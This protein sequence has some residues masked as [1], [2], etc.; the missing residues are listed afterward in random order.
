MQDGQNVFDEATS[1]YGEWGVDEAL[2]TL[3]HST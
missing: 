2:D 3:E 1:A